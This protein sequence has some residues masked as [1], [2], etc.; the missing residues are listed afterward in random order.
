MKAA[1]YIRTSTEEQNPQLQKDKCVQ[2]ARENGFNYQIFEEKKSAWK[3]DSKRTEFAH[4]RNLI[5]KGKLNALV[6]WDLDRLYRNRR[7]LSK[8]FDLCK[9]KNCKI[10]T[11][12]QEFLKEINKAPEP[13]NEI[14]FNMLIQ[15][16]GWIAEEESNKKSERVKLAIQ[17]DEY[18]K[19]KSKYGKVWGRPK[20]KKKYDKQIIELYKQG[21]SLKNISEKVKYWDKNNNLKMVSIGYVHKVIK[22]YKED[23]MSEDEEEKEETQESGECDSEDSKDEE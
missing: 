2:L 11:V 7:R 4:I 21:N 23:K 9:I 20:I 22:K 12:R 13:W 19:T 10:Y 15:I 3:K 17:R 16:M 5:I 1:I 6:C 18:G 8:F 14:M